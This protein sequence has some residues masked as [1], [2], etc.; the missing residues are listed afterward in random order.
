MPIV[1]VYNMQGSQT[2]EIDLKESVFGIKA[3]E[4][5]VHQA[6]K[7]YLAS[8][9]LGTHKT[10]KRDEVRGG[11]KKPWRQKGTGRAR[12]GS[13]RSP[14][15][16][17][18]GTIFGPHPRSYTFTMPRKARRIAIKSALSSKIESSEIIVIDEIKL[19]EI[20]TKQIVEFLKNFDSPKKAL[21]ITAVKNEN[22]LKSS[23]NI[24]GVKSIISVGINVF[25]L[26]Y[27]DKIF[28][29]RAAISKI[30]EVCI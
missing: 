15:W 20:K 27:H 29:E 9:R 24:T 3:N 28:V 5:L 12:A 14:L 4:A 7:I 11:G 19:A 23:L 10:K 8:K 17:G 6:V 25:D 30:Q 1:K 2:D 22:I 13:I 18:G 16:V 21:I 26:L